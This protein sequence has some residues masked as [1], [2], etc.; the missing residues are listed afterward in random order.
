MHLLQSKKALWEGGRSLSSLLAGIALLVL[1]FIPLLH[2]W[3]AIP[4]GLP[5]FLMS[6]LGIIATYLIAAGGF[7][8]L[9]DG[10]LQWG[11]PF[12]WVT[13]AVALC[14][15][16]IGI[17]PIL[18]TFGAISFTIPFF[19]ATFYSIIFTVEGIFLFIGAF[20]ME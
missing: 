4:F 7:Y 6:F 8:L 20:I 14:V 15:L 12:A 13:L 17:I 1:G 10:F 3:G 16:A 11:N 9:V 5:D 18:H 2:N 19:T